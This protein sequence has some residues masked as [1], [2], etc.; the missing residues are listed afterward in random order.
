[1][2]AG[3]V[4]FSPIRLADLRAAHRPAFVDM[5][6]AWCVTCLVNERVALERPAVRDAFAARGVT[7]LVG[8][9][10]RQDAAITAYLRAHGRDGVPLYV[11]YPAQGQ[12]VVL[13]QTLTESL[14]LRAIGGAAG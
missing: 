8:D 1:V 6:A 14:V 10:T 12:P 7:T 3:A 9:W 13:P 11:F 5:T 2:Q 4:V